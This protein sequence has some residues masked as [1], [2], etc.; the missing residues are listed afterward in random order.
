MHTQE[1]VTIIQIQKKPLVP[2]LTEG[3]Q[4][5]GM[6]V[7]LSANAP[8]C[9]SNA[10]TQM[11]FGQV[12]D[13]WLA[14]KRMYL[15]ESSYSRYHYLVN[16]H[17]K[18]SLGHL[19][20]Q[21]ITRSII[22]LYINTLLSSGRLDGNGGLSAKTVSD[23]LLILKG[24]V[25]YARSID[26]GINCALD[27]TRVRQHRREMRVLSLAEQQSLNKVLYKD[28][29]P[30][31]LGVL[32]S[33]YAGLRLGEVCALQWKHIDLI[34][35]VIRVRQTMQRIQSPDH[36]TKTR[37]IITEPKSECSRRDVPLPDHLLALL[38]ECST[39]EPDAYVLTAQSEQ[40]IEPRTMQNRFKRYVAQCGIAPANYHALR[41]SFATRC[42]ELGIDIKSLSEILG[43]SN[44][45]TTLNRY[46]HSSLER[47]RLYMK[48][49]NNIMV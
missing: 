33:L 13:M 36:G 41:H 47:K 18:P 19:Q 9:L 12:L 24:A 8:S 26:Y 39:K 7:Y 37:I 20:I 16:R 46:V 28:T 5:E 48:K 30:A 35:G 31:K 40:Y 22:E 11:S 17:I 3:V 38:R 43:H 45:N 2:S 15:K 1:G 21:C 34:A 25:E 27:K 44:V 4:A 42:V 14:S 6:A 49:L 10:P 32:I 23:M 29:S